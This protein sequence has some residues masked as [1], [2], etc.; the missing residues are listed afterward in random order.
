MDFAVQL[1]FTQ[2]RNKRKKIVPL[3]AC[4]KSM[5]PRPRIE[6]CG[7]VDRRD[8]LALKSLGEVARKQRVTTGPPRIFIKFFVK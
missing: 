1:K 4:E 7:K 8:G 2:D 6:G 3:S 5:P